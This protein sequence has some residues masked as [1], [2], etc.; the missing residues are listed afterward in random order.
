MNSWRCCRS[1]RRECVCSIYNI[2]QIYVC[3]MISP[4]LQQFLLARNRRRDHHYIWLDYT[5]LH[6]N[7]QTA[8]WLFASICIRDLKISITTS[9]DESRRR[10]EGRWQ[11][12]QGLKSDGRSAHQYMSNEMRKLTI[13]TF[14]SALCDR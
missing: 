10:T 3:E 7:E 6:T 9:C 8:H 13:V 14:M 11:G 2:F 5:R 12:W 4:L 1:L